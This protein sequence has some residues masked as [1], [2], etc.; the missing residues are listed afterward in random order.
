MDN[1][2]NILIRLNAVERLA[3]AGISSNPTPTVIDS[4][5]EHI[6]TRIAQEMGQLATDDIMTICNLY[7]LGERGVSS[8]VSLS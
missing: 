3:A 4:M 6:K 5:K 1:S 2:E 8:D 7:I